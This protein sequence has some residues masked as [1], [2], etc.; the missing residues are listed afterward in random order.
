MV[1][2]L[3]TLRENCQ[4]SLRP[5]SYLQTAVLAT[6]TRD[7]HLEP[8]KWRDWD[9]RG[10][11]RRTHPQMKERMSRVLSPNVLD[12]TKQAMPIR[13]SLLSWHRQ[14]NWKRPVCSRY[15]KPK[16]ET[17]ILIFLPAAQLPVPR[18]RVCDATEKE[19]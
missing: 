9:G 6:A 8:S 2:F 1:Y 11:R 4:K 12:R 19:V 3:G 5:L 13:G 7:D 17:P 10:P 18:H 14:G 15:R 16:S